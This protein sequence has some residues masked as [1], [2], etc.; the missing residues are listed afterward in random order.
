MVTVD[1]YVS[2]DGEKHVTHECDECGARCDPA[3][4]NAQDWLFLHNGEQLCWDC[5]MEQADFMKIE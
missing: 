2:M 3:S 5:L 1:K 4:R